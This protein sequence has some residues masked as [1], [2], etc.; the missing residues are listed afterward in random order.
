MQGF[1]HALRLVLL[2]FFTPQECKHFPWQAGFLD[3]SPYIDG[4]RIAHAQQTC[5]A[6][7]QLYSWLAA[8]GKA[9]RRPPSLSSA[10]LQLAEPWAQAAV[11]DWVASSPALQGAAPTQ[12]VVLMDIRKAQVLAGLPACL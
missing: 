6:S 4:S 10:G 3:S 11:K 2:G 9:D 8:A 12:Q 7:T 1:A 5:M